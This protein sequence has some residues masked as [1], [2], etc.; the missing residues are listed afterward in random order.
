MQAKDI[1]HRF[2]WILTL[3]IVSAFLCGS[4]AIVPQASAEKSWDRMAAARYLDARASFWSEGAKARRKLSTA[5]LSCHTAVPYL[6]ARAAL[7]QP[8]MPGPAKD[9][10][11]DVETRVA[12]WSD[13]RVWYEEELGAEKP[14]QSRATESVLNALVL[15]SRDRRARRP[16][17]A[18]AKTALA[19]MWAQQNVDGN[20]DWLHFG[21]IPWETDGSDYWGAALAA[22]AGMSVADEVRPPAESSAKLRAYLRAGMTTELSLHNRIALLWAASTWGG[23]LSKTE[24]A[25]LVE[26]I[27]ERQQ[28]DGGFRPRKSA[29]WWPKDTSDGYVTAFGTFVLQLAHD[30]RAAKSIARGVGWLEK[31]QQPDGRWDAVSPNKDRRG[32]DTFTRLLMSDAATGFAVLALTSQTSDTTTA[33]RAQNPRRRNRILAPTVPRP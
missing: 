9:L 19:H 4:E 23:L 3:A 8:S 16:L 1:T 22:V 25:G 24:T 6:L 17:T 12:N 31:N 13:A 11:S 29:P 32:E 5:C 14:A 15:T 10:F 18:E 7:G 27:V 26:E 30:P 21:L 2:H 33:I 28:P 20:W